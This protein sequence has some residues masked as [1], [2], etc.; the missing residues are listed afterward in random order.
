MQQDADPRPIRGGAF[1]YRGAAVPEYA[2][3]SD[4]DPDPGEV[5]WAWVPFE[6]DP[7]HGKD[8]PLAIVG[9]AVDK[10]GDLVCF[11][12]SSKDRS[13]EAGWVLIGAGEWDSEHRQSWVNL[14]RPLAVT[15]EAVRREGGQ[16]SREQFDAVVNEARR[17]FPTHS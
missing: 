1:D 16:L 6:E 11:L 4:Y 3:E 9:R 15:P 17:M 10:P 12:L 13:K 5:V 2:P 7:S 14:N 8:R